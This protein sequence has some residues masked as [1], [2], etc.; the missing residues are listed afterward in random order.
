MLLRRAASHIRGL[1]SVILH[2]PP[3]HAPRESPTP[4]VFVSS[5]SWDEG[6][7]KGTPSIPTRLAL[8][9]FTSL[10]I[11]LQIPEASMK[12]SVTMMTEY[13]DELFSRIRSSSIPFPPVIFS[14]E[15][16]CLIA[17]T[18]I[19][20][21]PAS[22]LVL[23]SPPIN[24]AELIG[25]KLPTNLAEFDYEPKFP[26]A[27]IDTPERVADLLKRNR[28]CQSGMVDVIPVDQLNE[29]ETFSQIVQWLDKL[30]I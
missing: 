7:L 24:N 9:G 18:Y 20:S 11:D 2:T 21:N 4:L 19:S 8:K 29:E 12:N 14:R 25:T 26:I 6:S 23:I 15:A 10:Q 1:S 17:Q 22:G 16:T 3:S 27:V 13:E 28:I 30:G 5:S